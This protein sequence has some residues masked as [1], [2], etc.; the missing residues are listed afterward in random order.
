MRIA[1]A[2]L[3]ALATT[4]PPIA[5]QV[6]DPWVAEPV[7]GRRATAA[8][9]VLEN[10]GSDEVRLTRCETAAAEVTEIHR[11]TERGGMM[12]MGREDQV[13]V[14][15]RGRVSFEPGGYHVMLIDLRKPLAAGDRVALRLAFSDGRELVVDAP[16]RRREAR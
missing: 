8:Y 7:A 14:P 1:C 10:R 4:L 12:S 16:V 5:V 3:L 2:S 15:A 11:V 9:F 13:A 6:R